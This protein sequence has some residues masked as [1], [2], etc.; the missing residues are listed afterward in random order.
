MGT[1]AVGLVQ[2]RE[3]MD[4][5]CKRPVMRYLGGKW[6]LAP[7]IISHF[8]EHSIYTEAYGGAASVLLRKARC[9]AEVY[10]DLD[11]EVECETHADGGR[12]RVEVVCR[13]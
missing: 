6:R 8:P 4:T 13:W 5:K 1:G 7:W 9:H 12:D 11:G 3:L 2:V 10:N